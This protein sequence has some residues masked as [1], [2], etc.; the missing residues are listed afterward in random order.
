MNQILDNF[1]ENWV[2]VIWRLLLITF[3][4]LAAVG[5]IMSVQYYDFLH[6]ETLGQ[7]PTLSGIWEQANTMLGWAFTVAPLWWKL[8][9]FISGGLVILP[10]LFI[11]VN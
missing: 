6:P 5:V 8:V 4:V 1:I 2:P 11:I 9:F 3:F 7:T 10:R